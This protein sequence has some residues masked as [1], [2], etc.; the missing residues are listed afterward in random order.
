MLSTAVATS[1]GAAGAACSATAVSSYAA[2]A[3]RHRLLHS[4]QRQL[5]LLRLIRLAR[6]LPWSAMLVHQRVEVRAGEL[7][8]CAGH[9]GQRKLCRPMLASTIAASAITARPAFAASAFASHCVACGAG[10]LD[11]E[12]KLCVLRCV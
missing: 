3:K 9:V 5:R 6:Q 7:P 10:L 4:Q 2:H 11:C 1:F 12:G 8:G